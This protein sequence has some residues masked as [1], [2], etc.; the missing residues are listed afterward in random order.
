MML[1]LRRIK[2][3]D[4]ITKEDVLSLKNQYNTKPEY[5]CKDD[6]CVLVYKSYNY[7]FIDIPD[8]YGNSTSYIVYTCSYDDI[9][10]NRCFNEKNIDGINYSLNCNND[11]ECL[12]N[13][14][15]ENHC[16]YNEETP[17]VYC[18]DIYTDKLFVGKSS[19]M[20]CGKPERN[21]CEERDE[22]SSRQCVKNR[23]SGPSGGP[24][25]SDSIQTGLEGLIIFGGI[26]IIIIIILIIVC[27]CWCIKR[28][29]N[30]N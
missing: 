6:I 21:P 20:Y 2:S 24:S 22:C 26:F 18:S 10:L 11:S 25:D 3:T 15:Y 28:R 29:R 1:Y 30:K 14:C 13:K 7:Y 5:Y 17:I 19:Y 12:S 9:E 8:R 27:C 4:V 23:C 16:V